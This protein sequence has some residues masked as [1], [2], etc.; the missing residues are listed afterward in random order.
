VVEM[1]LHFLAVLLQVPP[2]QQPFFEVVAP[3][4]IDVLQPP[5]TFSSGVP[6]PR[7]IN[8]GVIHFFLLSSMFP[9]CVHGIL[10]IRMLYDFVINLI[11]PVSTELCE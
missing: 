8:W 10:F 3:V 7:T 5:S 6:L 2:L 9:P 1:T 4:S 11:E